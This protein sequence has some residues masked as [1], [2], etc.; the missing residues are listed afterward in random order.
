MDKA[1]VIAK[2]NLYKD[3]PVEVAINGAGDITVYG[4]M[5]CHIG[6][7]LLLFIWLLR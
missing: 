2:L 3:K 5:L 6:V 1:E 7:G 4:N